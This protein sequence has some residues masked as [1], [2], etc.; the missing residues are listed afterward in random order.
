MVA[1]IDNLYAIFRIT[2]SKKNKTREI[3]TPRV[4]ISHIVFPLSERTI[5]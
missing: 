1:C 5:E 2:R 3:L 4:P